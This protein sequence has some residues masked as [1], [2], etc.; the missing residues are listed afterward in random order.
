MA[1]PAIAPPPWK[2]TL[3]I[4]H[5]VSN[6]GWSET[7]YINT[8]SL[9]GAQTSLTLLLTSRMT[10]LS[11]K[12]SMTYARLSAMNVKGDGYV[13]NATLPLVGGFVP[14][15]ADGGQP[16]SCILIRLTD[17][18]GKHINRLLHGIP[19][20]D[21]ADGTIALTAPYATVLNAFFVVVQGN[22]AF[23]RK[24]A[25]APFAEF[26]PIANIATRYATVK[27]VGRPFGLLRGRAAIR[28]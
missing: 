10:L 18:A 19:E 21:I 27:K 12:Y 9:S 20:E 28:T 6:T 1:D 5:S 23:R 13:T 26:V 7:Y 15:I 14:V 8:A 22:C 16:G 24:I 3:F 4:N 25:A 17:G 11:N 2:A